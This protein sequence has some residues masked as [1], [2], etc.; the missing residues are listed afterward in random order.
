L[1]PVH[2]TWIGFAR[3]RLLRGYM[4]DL[5]ALVAPHLGRDVVD[6]AA[7]CSAQSEVDS[8]FADT[9]LPRLPEILL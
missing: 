4:Y 2:T 1:F 9:T 6:R 7:R 8:L 5:L 3:D